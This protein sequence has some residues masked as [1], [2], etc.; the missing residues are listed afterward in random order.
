MQ[1]Q[2]QAVW[3]DFQYHG[4][5]LK[6]CFNEFGTKIVGQKNTFYIKRTREVLENTASGPKNKAKRTQK[7]SGEVV[8]NTYL[9]KKRT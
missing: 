1:P 9:W 8:E 2:D 7:R 6:T 3:P 4:K 5:P